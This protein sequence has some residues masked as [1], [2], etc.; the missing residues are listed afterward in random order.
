MTIATKTITVLDPSAKARVSDQ[1]IAARPS[2]LSGKV[3]GFLDN[4]KPNVDILMNRIEEVLQSRCNLKE[5]VRRRKSGA[6][7]KAPK[8]ILDELSQ[9]CDLIIVG[10]GD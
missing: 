7:S 4:S 2:D 6:G 3:V 10:V 8:A 5:V 9:S 1:E